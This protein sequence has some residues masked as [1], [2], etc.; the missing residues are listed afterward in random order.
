M[1]NRYVYIYRNLL[2][3]IK[4]IL[5]HKTESWLSTRLHRKCQLRHVRKPFTPEHCGHGKWRPA[6]RSWLLDRKDFERTSYPMGSTSASGSAPVT[7]SVPRTHGNPFCS[8][9]C[10]P[11]GTE[12]LVH[13]RLTSA[14]LRGGSEH[15]EYDVQL[16]HWHK[17]EMRFGYHT[18]ITALL[19]NVT[20]FVL[21]ISS[22]RRRWIFQYLMASKKDHNILSSTGKTSNIRH[23]CPA[24][25]LSNFLSAE[26]NYVYESVDRH[27]WMIV[28][29][30]RKF[31]QESV[32]YKSPYT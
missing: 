22:P 28:W 1:Q 8:W 23:P 29:K 21:L 9:N 30:Y 14:S 19:Q 10:L 13:K 27:Q 32:A 6:T 20:R 2:L 16:S 15:K 17:F 3:G 5:K 24:S 31:F 25:S 12:T 7:R 26:W 4:E 18:T 11:G